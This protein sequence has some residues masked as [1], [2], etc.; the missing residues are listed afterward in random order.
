MF[1]KVDVSEEVVI[2]YG[3]FNLGPLYP[4]TY[5]PGRKNNLSITFDKVRDIL[6]GLGFMEII[7]P[8]VISRNLV[9][10]SFFGR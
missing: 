10:R 6:I 9:K 2:G 3:I 4:G 1:D 5:F 8:N 7:N